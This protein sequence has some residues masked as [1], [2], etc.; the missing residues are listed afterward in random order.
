MRKIIASMH[1]SLDGFAAGPNGEIDWVKLD[2]ELFDLVGNFTAEA[3][4]ALYGRI[5][6]EMMESYWPTAAD[7]PNAT[8]HD[9]EHSRWYNGAT[10]I[11]L[12]RTMRGKEPDKTIVMSGNIPENIYN[13]K[14]QKGKNILIFGSLSSVRYLMQLN[15]IDDFW[16]FIN[17]IILAQGIPLFTGLKDKIK[18]H[19][20]AVKEFRCGVT[21][22]HYT[23]CQ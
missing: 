18:L 17:P 1:V 11:V 15:F 20:L 12:S 13:L 10:K 22:L 16:L 3:D 2:D 21:G 7:K 14:R 5:T 9:I 4:T 23:L 19:L 6:Y 8:K